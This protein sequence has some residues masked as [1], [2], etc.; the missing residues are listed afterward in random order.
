GDEGERRTSFPFIL[1]GYQPVIGGAMAQSYEGDARKNGRSLLRGR[2]QDRARGAGTGGHGR[3][4]GQRLLIR[5]R[6]ERPGYIAGAGGDRRGYL[7][8]AGG[9]RQRGRGG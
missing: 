1:S 9:W 5:A 2:R 3:Q 6:K 7:A 8:G 4:T